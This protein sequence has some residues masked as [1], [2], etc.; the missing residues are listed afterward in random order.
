MARKNG[1]PE[2]AIVGLGRFGRSV[3]LTL[4]E[5]GYSVLGI[6]QDTQIVQHLADQL[7]QVVALDA[8]N[9][10]ALRAMDISS[11]DTVVVAIGSD[12]ESNL[13]TTVALK[14]L[15]VNH[16]VCKALNQQ[17]RT[18]LLRVGADRVVLPEHEAGQRLAWR[19]AEPKV[20]DHLDLGSGFSVAEIAVPSF[21][22]GQSLIEARLRQRY[23][24]NVLAIRRGG[25]QGAL[26]ITPP[27]EYI[28]N[29]SDLLLLIGT[30]GN[31]TT[32]CERT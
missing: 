3:A 22:V 7:T 25:S 24:I 31:I 19:L 27:P 2:F 28:F 5:R 9:E 10:D 32:F 29:A 11:F 4:A 26:I 1:K 23:G 14:N 15:G 17:Q 6:D 8:T 13:L 16:V 20:L 18:I 21:L 30:D 12:F